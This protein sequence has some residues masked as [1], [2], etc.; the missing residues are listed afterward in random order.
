MTTYTIDRADFP[1]L[2]ALAERIR[3]LVADGYG[4]EVTAAGVVVYRV[5]PF[6]SVTTDGGPAYWLKD[7]RGRT[8]GTIADVNALVRYAEAMQGG[9]P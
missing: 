6:P 2:A 4:V 7:A 9:R 8:V 5:D 1:C 3:G